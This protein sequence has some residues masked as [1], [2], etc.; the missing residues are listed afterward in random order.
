ME[1]VKT[2]KDLSINEIEEIQG[3]CEKFNYDFQFEKFGDQDGIVIF[4][5]Q[6]ENSFDAHVLAAIESY[7]EENVMFMYAEGNTCK[8]IIL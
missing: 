3:V 1:T 6:S 7:C 5:A 2:I 4:D 8:L